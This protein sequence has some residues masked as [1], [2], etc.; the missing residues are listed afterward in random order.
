M[1]CLHFSCL[2]DP[3]V[4]CALLLLLAKSPRYLLISRNTERHGPSYSS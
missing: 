3:L 1:Y 2:R 4:Y